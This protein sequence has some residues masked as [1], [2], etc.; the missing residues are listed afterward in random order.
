MQ[1]FYVTWYCEDSKRQVYLHGFYDFKSANDH[2]VY[3]K[4]LGISA[5]ARRENFYG[6]WYS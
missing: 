4:N 1:C 6:K 2:V 5:E 3:L